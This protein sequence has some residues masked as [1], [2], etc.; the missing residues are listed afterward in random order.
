MEKPSKQDII[1]AV[2][3]EKPVDYYEEAVIRKVYLQAAGITL[4]VI[5]AVLVIDYI[6]AHNFN[7]LVFG[8]ALTLIGSG[9]LLE[10]KNFKQIRKIVSG[11]IWLLIA[12][13]FIA[14]SFIK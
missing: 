8:I 9:L 2:K 11:I 1:N 14:G 4:I 6:V 5:M 13:I 7:F 3:S 10:G 12:V